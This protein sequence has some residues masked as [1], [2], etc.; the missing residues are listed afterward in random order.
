MT[1]AATPTLLVWHRYTAVLEPEG[2][3]VVLSPMRWSTLTY[4]VMALG[5]SQTGNI[6]VVVYIDGHQPWLGW[7]QETL[8]THYRNL[9]CTLHKRCQALYVHITTSR[10]YYWKPQKIHKPATRGRK[11]TINMS[12][13]LASLRPNCDAIVHCP[14]ENLPFLLNTECYT[15]NDVTILPL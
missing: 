14:A 2:G 3:G 8:T 4:N 10:N 12:G 7:Q 11:M 13:T 1:W 9:R 6:Y 15:S 5:Y